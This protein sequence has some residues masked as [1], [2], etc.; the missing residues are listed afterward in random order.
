MR[1]D[2]FQANL[3]F[4]KIDLDALPV[5]GEKL[6]LFFEYHVVPGGEYTNKFTTLL[7]THEGY[8]GSYEDE[9]KQD[10][11]FQVTFAATAP[12]IYDV[13][14]QKTVVKVPVGNYI[15]H[16][17]TFSPVQYSHDK[18]E[19]GPIEYA[20]PLD[21]ENITVK[22]SCNHPTLAVSSK[23]SVFVSGLPVKIGD[24][25]SQLQKVHVID[26]LNFTNTDPAPE[27][28]RESR[29]HLYI[30]KQMRN[31]LV[32]EISIQIP[33]AENIKVYD[34]VGKVASVKKHKGAEMTQLVVHPRHEL[35]GQQKG[36]IIIEYDTNLVQQDG[37]TRG[38]IMPPAA[39]I[40]PTPYFTEMK[41]CAYPA[42]TS[43]NVSYMAPFPVDY[44]EESDVERALDISD[45][46]GM[47][48][49]KVLA[50]NDYTL[51][52][53]AMKYEID[54]ELVK[55]RLV[56]I[57]GGIGAFVMSAW[58]LRLLL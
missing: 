30:L 13:S 51:T 53:F 45:R 56:K 6:S 23:R 25:D 16:N 12:Q 14:T 9:A 43:K 7:T 21:F 2:E 29:L 31:R 55:E 46:H 52:N 41:V 34:R 24:F 57:A 33:N 1:R 8:E 44:E 27:G 19:L 3:F 58:L 40:T 50:D 37:E 32:D 36:Q 17:T 28:L 10:R 42:S 20:Q 38:F 18:L 26:E 4:V 11:Q 49:G 39:R 47:C 35:L 15:S 5:P 48:F 22:F 54:G